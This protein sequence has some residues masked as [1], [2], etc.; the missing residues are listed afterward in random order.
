LSFQLLF[1][2]KTL[3]HRGYEAHQSQMEIIC[4]LWS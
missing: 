3:R 4:M 2:K 1:I